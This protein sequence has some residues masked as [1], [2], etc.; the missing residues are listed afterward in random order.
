M[1][2][3]ALP[4]RLNLRNVSRHIGENSANCDQRLH[5]SWGN[6]FGFG[7]SVLIDI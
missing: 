5:P 1:G 3:G 7:E 2:F 4:L 6:N